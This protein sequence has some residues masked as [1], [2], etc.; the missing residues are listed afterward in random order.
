VL[1]KGYTLLIITDAGYRNTWFTEVDAYGW[2]WLDR[3]RGEVCYKLNE[4]WALTKTLYAAANNKARYIGTVQI[5]RKEP[6]PCHL[7]AFKSKDKHRKDKRS[8]RSGNNHFAKT[9]YHRSAKE[10]WVLATNLPPKLFYAVQIT[11]L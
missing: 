9:L 6:M 11:T 5:A 7:Y 4:Q 2:Y 8:R 1:P 10:P 3:L